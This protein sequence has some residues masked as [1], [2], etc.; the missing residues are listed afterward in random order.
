MELAVESRRMI[1]R[2]ASDLAIVVGS[3]LELGKSRRYGSGDCKTADNSRQRTMLL[4]YNLYWKATEK[5]T[6]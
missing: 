4:T 5:Y 2:G 1:M 3:S 6:R